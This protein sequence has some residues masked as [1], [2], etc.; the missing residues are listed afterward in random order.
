MHLFFLRLFNKTLVVILLS[1]API[2]N[3][4]TYDID[5]G[6]DLTGVNGLLV[7]STL[8]DVD[9]KEGTFFDIFVDAA[10]LDFTS[11]AES[12]IATNQLLDAINFNQDFTNSPFNIFGCTNTA[13]CLIIS[14][15]ELD[16]NGFHVPDTIVFI[17]TNL[18]NFTGLG[19]FNTI[20][21]T[22]NTSNQVYADWQLSSSI[23]EPRTTV[24]ICF[25]FLGLICFSRRGYVPNSLTGC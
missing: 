25:G 6:G 19:T 11:Q 20:T 4:A 10:G 5:S 9:F 23:P 14:P 21:D 12:L 8:Y 1:T 13:S 17:Q 15:Y 24:L 3:A 7:G 18:P 22:T 16:N 2:L